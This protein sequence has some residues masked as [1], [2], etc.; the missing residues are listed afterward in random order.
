MDEIK[1][2]STADT[3]SPSTETPPASTPQPQPENQFGFGLINDQPEKKSSALLY[4]LGSIILIVAVGYTLYDF[5][6]IGSNA[7]AK[8]ALTPSVTM[9]PA[10]SPTPVTT[11][12][13]D[14]S[15]LSITVLNGSGKVGVASAMQT[16]LENDGY[17]VSS[18]GNAD[19]YNYTETEIHV[20]PDNQDYLPLLKKDLSG[21]YTIGT[22]DT[23]YS[24]SGA[25][26]IVGAQ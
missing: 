3:P 6:N 18:I 14:K 1:T 20:S 5:F 25:E 9:T 26:V 10:P 12:N 13:L 21:S 2:H 19:N 15:K 24:G 23:N 17:T 8:T 11:A 22:A 7:S 4:I 16:I